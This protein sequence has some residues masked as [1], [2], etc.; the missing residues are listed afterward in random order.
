MSSPT[1]VQLLYNSTTTVQLSTRAVQQQYK[2]NSTTVQ[3]NHTTYYTTYI[4]TYITPPK[5]GDVCMY[6]GR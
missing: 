2:Y 1:A 4:H 3:L 6:V 5:G